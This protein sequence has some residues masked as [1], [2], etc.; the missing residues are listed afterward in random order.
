MKKAR[1]LRPLKLTKGRSVFMINEYGAY[2]D[3]SL[4][5][6][7]QQKNAVSYSLLIKMGYK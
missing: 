7:T 6:M 4:D 2:V 3:Q 1:K 5:G